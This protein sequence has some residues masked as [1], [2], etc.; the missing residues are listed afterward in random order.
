MRTLRWPPILAALCSFWSKGA[1]AQ[2][3]PLALLDTLPVPV[4][5]AEV[6]GERMAYYEGGSRSAPTVILLPNLGW[7]SQ[8]WAQNFSALA[9]E[10]HVVAVDPIGFGRSSKPLIDYKMDTWTD[11]LNEF[12]RVRQIARAFF[13]G[14]VMGGALSVQMALD[15]PERVL[16]IVVAA[17]NSGPGPH[18][19]GRAIPS[20]PSLAGTR[21]NLRALFFDST[22][23]TDAFVRERFRFRLRTNDGYTVQRHLADHRLPYTKDELARIQVP[24]FVVWCREDRIT[25]LSWGEQYAAALPRGQLATLESCGHLPNLEQPQAFNRAVLEFLRLASLHRRAL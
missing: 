8:A 4:R 15:H 2:D 18:E 21:A 14:A 7:D 20:A 10:Y 11:F 6:F 3:R 17:S 1:V 25:P 23:V 16:G 13:A 19:G 5:Y 12:M 9:Q 22:L 24:A